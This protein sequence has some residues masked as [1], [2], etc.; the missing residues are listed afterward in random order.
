MANN[1]NKLSGR[2]GSKPTKVVDLEATEKSE[3]LEEAV[4][5]A[6]E[7]K[8]D[9]VSEA[10]D[11]S[12]SDSAD[13]ESAAEVEGE[14]IASVAPP[15][16]ANASFGSLLFSAIL[17]GGV[18]LGGASLIGP[19]SA[20]QSVPVIGGLFASDDDSGAV[21][22]LNS[23]IAALKDQIAKL[24][25]TPASV[26]PEV[27]DRLAALESG[28]A[29]VGSAGENNGDSPKAE[30]ALNLANAAAQKADEVS[31]KIAELSS[32]IVEGAGGDSVDMDALKAALSGELTVLASKVLTIE[33]SLGAEN[34]GQTTAELSSIKE[35]INS[36][37][38]I[39]GKVES[40]ST[41]V[42]GM[43]ANSQQLTDTI[44]SLA[45]RLKAVET[46]VDE[47]ILPSMS[48]VEK[49]AVAAVESQKVA[50]SV[51]ARALSA[52][53]ENGGAFS[54]E[55]AS[56]EALLGT[57][58]TIE[59]LRAL[60]RKGIQSK[61]GLLGRVRSCRGSNYFTSERRYCRGGRFGSFLVQRTIIGQSPAS[62]SSG[63]R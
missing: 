49:A 19:N 58:D 33:K 45:D 12:E 62:R 30:E 2:R 18:A 22:G 38:D 15:Q 24:Q 10:I 6:S 1:R 53:L 54:S 27:S 28:I 29:A 9:A 39:P 59:A 43:S 51:S 37:S 25:S 56:A 14:A 17:G 26:S 52:V 23:E 11:T 36:L 4:E 5:A 57:N 31:Q 60:S 3:D 41:S 35:S 34:T 8:D 16:K 48:S 50:R 21:D 42:S 44:T 20:L 32:K 63:G 40:L 7:I 47:K 13:A 55:L 46:S 61:S